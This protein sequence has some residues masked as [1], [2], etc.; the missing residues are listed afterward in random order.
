MKLALAGVDACA[1][2]EAEITNGV[3]ECLGTPNGPRWAVEGR[4]E[5]VARGVALLATESG[6][7]SPNESMVAL[8][9][10]APGTIPE[11][12]RALGRGRR[13]R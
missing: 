11:F 10:L 9:Q 7:L 3:D 12:G 2:L 4:E 5:T 1:H 13:C 6:E 8:E